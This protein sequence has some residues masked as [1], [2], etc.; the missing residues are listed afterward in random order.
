MSQPNYCLFFKN[1][2]LTFGLITDCLKNK[3]V[4]QPEVGKTL[5]LGKNQTALVWSGTSYGSDA[6]GLAILHAKSPVVAQSAKEIDLEILHELVE[7]SHPYPLEELCD[8]A[9][10]NPEDGWSQ[11]SLLMALKDETYLFHQKKQDFFARTPEEIELLQAKELRE[12]DALKL[13]QSEQTWAASLKS[14]QLPDVDPKDQSAFDRFVGRL[15]NFLFYLEDHQ[16]ASYLGGLFDL[17]PSGG[18]FTERGLLDVLKV[19]GFHQSWGALQIER[20]GV[21][22]G[23]TDEELDAAQIVAQADPF[24]SVVDL[25]TIDLRHLG[26]ITVDNQDTKDFDDGFSVKR[27]DNGL[28]L[29]LHIADVA[30]YITPDHLLFEQ[31]RKRASTLYSPLKTFPMFPASLS[32]RFFSLNAE[33][34]HGAVSFRFI[35]DTEGNLVSSEPCRSVVH[36]DSN[37]SYDQLDSELEDPES[38]YHQVEL[39]CNKLKAQRLE[40]GALQ[41]ER[42]E[43]QLNLSDLDAIKIDPTVRQTRAHQLIEELA[44]LVNHQTARVAADSGR[45]NLFRNQEPYQVTRTLE[46]GEKP[47]LSDLLIRPASVGLEPLGHAAL[48]LDAYVQSS[49]PIRRFLDL[50]TQRMLLDWIAQKPATFSADDLRGFAGEAEA[51]VRQMGQLERRLLDHLKIKYL[52]QNPELTYQAQLFREFRGG[53]CLL[54][55]LDLDLKIEVPNTGYQPG[56]TYPVLIRKVDGPMDLV[57]VEIEVAAEEAASEPNSSVQPEEPV[58]EASV[59]PEANEA[60]ETPETSAEPLEPAE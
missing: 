28:E 52:S 9:L 30:S 23:F 33:E 22:A 21:Q 38:I 47:K 29:W 8:L 55:L 58:P 16:E 42:K 20:A 19:C 54:H 11:A 25:E 49:S 10:S 1:G 31:A 17:S 32:E 56:Q 5:N 14:G 43:I 36:L 12:A 46:E 51:R 50:V 18:V 35:F 24:S 4:I 3:W 41:L 45:P 44:I 2:K 48:G 37:W 15:K 27:L 59:D 53:R 39:V 34:D 26:G 13:Q 57:E 7:K 60:T 6:E 40:S